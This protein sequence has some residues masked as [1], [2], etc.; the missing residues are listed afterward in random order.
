M[1]RIAGETLDPKLVVLDKDGTLVA[2]DVL[3]HA[4]FDAWQDALTARIGLSAAL[5]AELDAALGVDPLTRAWDPR[6]PLTLASTAEIGLLLAGSLY[7]HLD[8]P[9]D[10]AVPLVQEAERDAREELATRDLVQPIGDVR[11][12]LQR[13]R[14]AGLLLAL[15]TT[16]E[17][18]ST[19]QN[20]AKL[21]LESFFQAVVCGDDG[22]PLKPAPD[23]A[24]AVCRRLGVAPADAIMVGDTIADL[25]MARRAGF[26]RAIGVTSGANSAQALAPHA[27]LVIPDIH[28]IEVRGDGD[29]STEEGTAPA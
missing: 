14:A 22:I 6:G 27:D 10:M 24:L 19:E 18:A 2:F 20:L 13:L 21:G 3:W 11:G 23:M 9:W 15:A 12:W 4:W 7:R 25:D 29:A 16:D 1:L 26:A 28:A 5:R 17:R 8:V